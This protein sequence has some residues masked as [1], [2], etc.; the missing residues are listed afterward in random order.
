M[1]S[2]T[3]N[4]TDPVEIQFGKLTLYKSLHS[5]MSGQQH[6]LIDICD[7]QKQNYV[8]LCI[9]NQYLKS[10]KLV[11]GLSEETKGGSLL[12]FEIKESFSLTHKVHFIY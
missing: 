11:T 1:Q 9:R 2:Y 3:K 6:L 10:I 4:N 5:S 8:Q 12:E 7:I